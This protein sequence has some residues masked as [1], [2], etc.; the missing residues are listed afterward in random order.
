MSLL[1]LLQLILRY[2]LTQ[3]TLGVAVGRVK[4][5]ITGVMRHGLQKQNC[6]SHVIR[7]KQDWC[8]RIIYLLIYVFSFSSL[9][10]CHF[11]GKQSCAK[12]RF[13]CHLYKKTPLRYKPRPRITFWGSIS[14]TA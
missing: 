2:E 4:L 11:Y 10:D 9:L 12:S 14:S 7:V 8:I 13:L 6:I 3:R 1:L 5:Y